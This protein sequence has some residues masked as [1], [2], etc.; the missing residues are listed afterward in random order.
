MSKIKDQL[1]E[2]MEATGMDIEEVLEKRGTRYG[3]Y[4]H[5]AATAQ[6]IK[7]LF[8]DGRFTWPEMETHMQESLDMIAN[9]LA[10]ILNGDP[11]YDDSW[12]DIAG[13]ATLVVKELEKGK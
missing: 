4:R 11:Y 8:R 1:I 9:K 7:S 12:R 3:A 5:V 10:R 2:E 13:Y 6:E